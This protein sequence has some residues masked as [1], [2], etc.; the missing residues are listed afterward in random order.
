MILYVGAMIWD[1]NLGPHVQRWQ[2]LYQMSHP[3]I[4]NS[5]FKSSWKQRVED[6]TLVENLPSICKPLGSI[7]STTNNR[8]NGNKPVQL[9]RE[10]FALLTILTLSCNFSD[11]LRP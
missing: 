6:E 10:V 11:S 3:S 5:K 2:M 8:V 7:L 1:L 4:P 9:S